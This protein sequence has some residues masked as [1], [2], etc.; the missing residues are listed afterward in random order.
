[1]KRVKKA[2]YKKAKRQRD[3]KG[4]KG[5]KAKRRESSEGGAREGLSMGKRWERHREARGK[6]SKKGSEKAEAG[7]SRSQR[8]RKSTAAGAQGYVVSRTTGRR[9]LSPVCG[10]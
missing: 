1:M 9:K 6:V 7:L 10:H 8:R 5:K 3:K 2:A 4:Q